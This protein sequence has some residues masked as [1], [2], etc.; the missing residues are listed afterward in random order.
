MAAIAY[1]ICFLNNKTRKSK[2]LLNP[3][4]AEWMLADF[5]GGTIDK[6]LTSNAGDTGLIPGPGRSHMLQSN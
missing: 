1:E 6:N 3:C 2:L 5:P 4:V